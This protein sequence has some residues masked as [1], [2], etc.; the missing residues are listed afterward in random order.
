MTLPKQQ[1]TVYAIIYPTCRR[2]NE[3]D[4]MDPLIAKH[5]FIDF[6][7]I[8]DNQIKNILDIRDALVDDC[9]GAEPLYQ[10]KVF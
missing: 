1:T 9:R 8:T 4:Q 10:S 6:Y 3:R 5:T 7:T 2:S